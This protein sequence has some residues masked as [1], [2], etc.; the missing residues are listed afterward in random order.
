MRNSATVILLSLLVTGGSCQEA[1]APADS[2]DASSAR[3]DGAGGGVP[4]GGAD[5]GVHEV[6]VLASHWLHF[7]EPEPCRAVGAE[8]LWQVRAHEYDAQGNRLDFARGPDGSYRLSLKVASR[9]IF[10]P[11]LPQTLWGTRLTSEPRADGTV[12]KVGLSTHHHVVAR[13][14]TGQRLNAAS[15]VRFAGCSTGDDEGALLLWSDV[16][17]AGSALE[18][19]DVGAVTMPD[20]AIHLPQ[21]GGNSIIA[22]ATWRLAGCATEPWNDGRELVV[23]RFKLRG[24]GWLEVPIGVRKVFEHAGQAHFLQVA[25]AVAGPGERCGHITFSL[26]RADFFERYEGAPQ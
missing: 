23:P 3:D 22:A 18:F 9:E 6:A 10:S 2:M 4:P 14:H 7:G 25:E 13:E 16:R 5:S 21:E 20:G 15:V 17:D 12:V 8:F 26:G 24:G 19:A 11:T 1:T